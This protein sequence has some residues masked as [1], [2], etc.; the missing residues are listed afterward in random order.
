MQAT[1]VFEWLESNPLAVYIRQSHLLY[2]TIEIVHIV[3]FILLTGSAFL[4]DI[5]LLGVSTRIPVTDLARHLL[6]WSRRSLLLVIPSGLL[7]FMTQATSLQD[8]R[9]F[10]TKLVLIVLAFANAGYF[11]R[12]T[13]QQ[14]EAWDRLHPTPTAAKA[15]GLIS[16]V[17][18]TGVITCGRFLAYLE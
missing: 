1:S 16:L 15:A 6:P 5:R 8:N 17:L 11:H 2:P 13:F 9:V 10:W 18:W 3:G 14:V 12:V 7:L 4:F